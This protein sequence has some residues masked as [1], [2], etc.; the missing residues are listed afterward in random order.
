M[1]FLLALCYMELCNEVFC[2]VGNPVLL[3]FARVV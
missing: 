3:S 1:L 2:T